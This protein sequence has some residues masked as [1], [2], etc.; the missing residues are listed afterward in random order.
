MFGD[1]STYHTTVNTLITLEDAFIAAYMI[2]VRDFST[3]NLRVLAS[4]IMGVEAEH[5]ALG[6]VVAAD[7]SLHYTTGLSGHH[8]FVDGPHAA[9][10]NIAY[11]RR[12]EPPLRTINDII[13]ALTPFVQS[14]AAG[15]STTPYPYRDTVPST[16]I[17]PHL[18]KK[19][20][21]TP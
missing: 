1:S 14:G 20:P 4:Q 18:D 12:F 10:N 11:E 7:L 15:F 21:D 2:G 3:S 19:L 9:V 13:G 17:L 5:R 16:V 6:R 8:E